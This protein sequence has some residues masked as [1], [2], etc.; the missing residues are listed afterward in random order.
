MPSFKI[1][2]IVQI[3][4]FRTINHPEM[5]VYSVDSSRYL[6]IGCCWFS[7]TNTLQRATFNKEQL[8]LIKGFN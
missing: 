4:G 5:S 7:S 2:D 8:V 3:K 1:G 6:I